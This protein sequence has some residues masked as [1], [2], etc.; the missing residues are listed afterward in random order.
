MNEPFSIYAVRGENK[1][2]SFYTSKLSVS[3]LIDLPSVDFN[4]MLSYN[5]PN[6]VSGLALFALSDT[7]LWH[8]LHITPTTPAGEAI[9]DRLKSNKDEDGV[10]GILEFDYGSKFVVDDVEMYN[11]IIN[12]AES[13][14][15]EIPVVFISIK[16][17]KTGAK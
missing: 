8:P 12:N 3:E 17:L 4:P 10:A 16:V 2:Y 11:Q 15:D 5:I 14:D 6:Y 13:M 1:K 9:A 7:A